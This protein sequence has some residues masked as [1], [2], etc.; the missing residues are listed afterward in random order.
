MIASL[1]LGTASPVRKDLKGSI[2]VQ[3]DTARSTY[4]Q[5]NAGATVSS[6]PNLG[7]YS[8]N[9]PYFIVLSPAYE[10]DIIVEK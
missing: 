1:F 3:P 10:D 7:T 6:I 8:R 9:R 5:E 2:T 4:I